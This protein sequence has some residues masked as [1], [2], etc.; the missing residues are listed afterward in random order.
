MVSPADAA[1]L[2]SE[3]GVAVEDVSRVAEGATLALEALAMGRS[4]RRH[5][6][7]LVPMSDGECHDARIMQLPDGVTGVQ[8]IAIDGA[9][10]TD[11]HLIV[12]AGTILLARTDG[13]AWP[14][15]SALSWTTPPMKLV[16]YVGSTF[17]EST[18]RA[19]LELT[20]HLLLEG[21]SVCG[22]SAAVISKTAQG[23]ST[24][25]DSE[26][27]DSQRLIA[28]QRWLA[29]VNPHRKPA[30]AMYAPTGWAFGTEETS[31]TNFSSALRQS[32]EYVQGTPALEWEISHML[33]FNPQVSAA[34]STGEAL[35][36]QLIEY[37]TLNTV[38]LTFAVP[39][40][41]RANMS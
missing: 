38:R 7:G 15:V 12:R 2:A 16:V 8:A 1:E 6:V 27:P 24:R 36:P 33:G 14:R 28:V 41:G 32:F 40:A 25:Y 21:P 9:E 4:V 18:R 23:V 39:V 13:A 30:S 31:L 35:Y 17:D 20:R 10:F 34:S 5:V 29:E 11:W 37:V 22:Q 19:A 3:F 26:K